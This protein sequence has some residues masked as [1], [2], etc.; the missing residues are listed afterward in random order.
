MDA[1]L[2]DWPTLKAGLED[3]VKTCGAETDWPSRYLA[4]AFS[5]QD[6]ET[7]REALGVIAGNYSPEVFGK[8]EVFQ[9]VSAWAEEP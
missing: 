1:K 2:L 4:S 5:F 8:P 7:A 9:D 3:L 6:K